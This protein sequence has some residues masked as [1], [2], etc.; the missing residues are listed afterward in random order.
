MVVA[1]AVQYAI[2]ALSVELFAIHPVVGS[3]VGFTVSL[4]V[5]Y[6]LNHQ[7][8]FGGTARHGR[9]LPRF[10]AIALGG[11]VLNS[12]IMALCYVHFGLHYFASQIVATGAV[13]FWSFTGNR[14]WSFR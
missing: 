10:V 14:L 2:L 7:V 13:F 1:T 4:F 6:Y 11:L 9:A 5:N 3:T 12:A 8:T